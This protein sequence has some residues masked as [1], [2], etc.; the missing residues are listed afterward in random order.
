MFAEQNALKIK[1]NDFHGN[2]YTN[3]TVA[4]LPPEQKE[5]TRDKVA[6]AIGLGNGK[7]MSTLCLL[8]KKI[9]F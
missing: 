4:N 2:Q 5:K 8:N 3:G 7:Q 9:L 6:E 1:A